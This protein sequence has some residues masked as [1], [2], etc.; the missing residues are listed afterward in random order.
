M[1][2]NR[3]TTLA[4]PDDGVASVRWAAPVRQD[5]IRRLYETDARGL[6]D[7]ALIDDVGLAL[8]L[9]CQSS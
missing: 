7:E 2:G 4:H 8:Y 9:R 5:K 1:T 6:T 3:D